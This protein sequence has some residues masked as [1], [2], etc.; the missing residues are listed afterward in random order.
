M[1]I[2]LE[3]LAFHIIGWYACHENKMPQIMVSPYLIGMVNYINNEER[4]KQEL[5]HLAHSMH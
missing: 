2:W 1:N 5:A 4:G 3:S